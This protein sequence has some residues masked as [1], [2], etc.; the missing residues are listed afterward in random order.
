MPSPIPT[1]HQTFS[2][3]STKC[4]IEA[5]QTYANPVA[6]AITDSLQQLQAIAGT[7][8]ERLKQSRLGAERVFHNLLLSKNDKNTKD[9][10]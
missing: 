2:L 5:S 8:S 1:P 7:D 4:G 6:G 9:I 10:S 3:E